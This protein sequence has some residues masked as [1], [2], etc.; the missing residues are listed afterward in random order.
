[1]KKSYPLLFALFTFLF[2]QACSSGNKETAEGTT[3]PLPFDLQKARIFIDSANSKFSD[4]FRRGDSVTLASYYTSDA[5]IL[6]SNSEP[7]TGKGILSV[8]GSMTSGNFK[9]FT[10]VTTDLTG[11]ENFLIETGNYVLK[12]SDDSIVDRGKYV[13]VYK[14]ENG[15]WKLYRDIG[16]TSLSPEE[17]D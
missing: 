17:T 6:L 11:D 10:F 12:G 3:M 9:D 7:I 8:W 16:N 14:K 1:M 5:A 13:V 2:V 4:A 15:V